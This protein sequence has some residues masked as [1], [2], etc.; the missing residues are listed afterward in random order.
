MS[1]FH[2]IVHRVSRHARNSGRVFRRQSLFKVAFVTAFVTFL[3]IGLFAMLLYGLRYLD[4]LGGLGKVIVHHLFATFFLS[5]SF[6]LIVSGIVTAYVTIFRSPEIPFLIV[7]P[8]R[9]SQ[10]MVYKFLESAFF[11]S[12]AFLFIVVPYVA[13]YAIYAKFPFLFILWTAVFSLPLLLLNAAIGAVI[14]IA[15]VRW[16]PAWRAAYWFAAALALVPL[17]LLVAGS[18]ETYDPSAP[19]QFN[20]AKL[21]PWLSLAAHPL[22]PSHWVSEGIFL[23]TQGIWGRGMLFLLMISTTALVSFV[24]I[25]WL[26]E[27]VFYDAWQRVVGSHAAGSNR[28]L[29]LEPLRRCLLRMPNAV[30]ALVVKDVR[31][32]FRDPMQW[33][34]ALVFF[35]LLAAY[36]ANL[37]SFNYHLLEE[38][39]RNTIA[40]LNVFSVGAV[41]C[42]LG[43][44]FAYPQLS[45]E[46]HGFWVIGLSPVRRR[47][48]LWVKFALALI[49]L[50]AISTGLMTLSAHM[51]GAAE[52]PRRAAIGITTALSFAIAGLS[53]GLG[54]VFVDLDNRNPAAI[55]SGFGGTLNLVLS[56]A[57]MLAVIVPFWGIFHMHYRLA[58]IDG[59]AMAR[60]TALAAGWAFLL[61]V[62]ATVVPLWFGA[63]SLE[64][65]EF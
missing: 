50:L 48:I 24:V 21:V 25:E 12:W 13:A 3:E 15:L 57:F 11:S 5:M 27:T 62:A 16:Y 63:R 20:L 22:M 29:L 10:I 7:R 26:G 18:H 33:S 14:T 43:A 54:A 42:S 52:A 37:R 30:R 8:F 64:R 31:I 2:A 19:V 9:M 38:G 6:M 41:M 32:F 4:H 49:P 28:P 35:G 55:V 60:Y 65:H 56:L 44:R 40:F 34:Q 39:Y 59:A 1:A 51:L 36:F 45:L 61:T 46:G 17:V 53:T 58:A 47:T 23:M